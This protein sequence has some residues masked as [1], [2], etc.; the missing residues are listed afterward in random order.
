MGVM[1]PTST[2]RWFAWAR[3]W[4]ACIDSRRSRIVSC[5][6][7]MSKYAVMTCATESITRWFQLLKLICRFRRPMRTE[8]R[9]ASKPKSRRSG[10][11][12]VMPAKKVSLGRNCWFRFRTVSRRWFASMPI[13]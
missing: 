10:W 13:L 6:S 8:A 12:S 9:F 7:V 11:S 4:S 3:P 5:A 2:R 1:S